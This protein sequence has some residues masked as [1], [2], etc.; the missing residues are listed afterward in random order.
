MGRE[1]GDLDIGTF[2]TE[3]QVA[4]NPRDFL[5]KWQV[6]ARMYFNYVFF[7]S[8]E[9]AFEKRGEKKTLNLFSQLHF[10]SSRADCNKRLCRSSVQNLKGKGTNLFHYVPLF[11]QMSQCEL[12]TCVID[13]DKP[14]MH[15]LASYKQQPKASDHCVTSLMLEPT[16]ARGRR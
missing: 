7:S 1:C 16:A 10:Q 3:G 9:T 11:N 6:V 5:Q 13:T 2:W 12:I 4:F 8:Q 14:N 15:Y